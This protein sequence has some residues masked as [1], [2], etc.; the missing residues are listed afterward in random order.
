MTDLITL[1]ATADAPEGYPVDITATDQGRADFVGIEEHGHAEFDRISPADLATI[2]SAVWGNRTVPI[3]TVHGQFAFWDPC[4]AGGQCATGCADGCCW[5]DYAQAVC[6]PHCTHPGMDIGVIK[7]TALYAAEGG[8]VEFAGRDGF[9][10]PF[11]VDVRTTGG[12]LHIYGHMWSIDPEVVQ[13]GQ[14]QPGQY[15]GTSG[16]Q[17]QGTTMNPDGSGPHLHFERRLANGCAAD[18]GPTLRQATVIRH[19]TPSAPPAFDGNPQQV[20]NTVFNPDRRTVEVAFN[21]LSCRRWANIQA[22]TTRDPLPKGAK[23][24]VLYW[25]EGEPVVGENRWWVATDGTRFHVAGTV[26]KPQSA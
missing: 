24:D 14:I 5:Y 8:R 16:E 1:A 26:E 23:V 17:V 21:G 2:T 18:P 9:Y 7:H 22:C 11:H 6:M 10:K 12:E 3:N 15:L 20:G 19:C 25:V 4:Q 13:N